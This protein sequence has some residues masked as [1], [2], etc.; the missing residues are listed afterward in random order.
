MEFLKCIVSSGLD[1]NIPEFDLNFLYE[2]EFFKDEYLLESDLKSNVFKNIKY[3]VYK[4]GDFIG[5]IFLENYNIEKMLDDFNVLIEDF[6]INRLYEKNIKE[7]L[8][9]NYSIFIKEFEKKVLKNPNNLFG[10]IYKM[11]KAAGI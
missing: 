4:N 9:E 3:N 6:D 7:T 1:N 10:E 5:S 8:L 2:N 11:R